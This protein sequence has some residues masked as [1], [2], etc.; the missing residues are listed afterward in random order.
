MLAYLERENINLHNLLVVHQRQTVLETYFYPYQPDSLHDIRSAAKSILSI[1]VGIALDEGR[2]QSVNQ[3]ILDF[4]PGRTFASV[5]AHKQRITLR[6]LLRM[7]S[8]L[9]WSDADVGKMMQSPDW[10]QFV[11]DGEMVAEPGTVFNY[12]TTNTHLLSAILQ[13]ATGMTALEYARQKLFDPLG[14]GTVRWQADPQGINMGGMGLWMT[15]R[16]MARIGQMMLYGG[17]GIVSES[18][19]KE[20][21]TPPD[22]EYAYLWWA[23]ADMF[24]AS[25]YGGQMI[26][27]LPQREMVVVLTAGLLD[28]PT[29]ARTLL[30][31]VIL[32]A[33][34]SH[35]TLPQ[36]Y[37]PASQFFPIPDTTRQISGQTYVLEANML[38][39]K[40]FRFEE[41]TVALTFSA[42]TITLPVGLDGLMRVSPVERL[43]LISDHDP[44]GLVGKWLDDRTFELRLYIINNPENWHI[45]LHFEASTVHI[46]LTDLITG[47][48][49][50]F[51]GH[52]R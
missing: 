3:P 10:I 13:Q 6:H 19:V 15:T 33:V 42:D 5:D 30:K 27:I 14:I 34:D 44:I 35:E 39:W 28:A 29:T 21:T 50:T 22:G 9:G 17:Q 12:S 40:A 41:Q 49:Q 26:Y 25:G 46:T 8:S 23:E 51:A 52:L 38:D 45:R 16:D 2:L 7:S 32:P 43:G 47:D 37:Q 31:N 48:Q 1:L 4:F 20:S 36:I 24:Y 18:W 11:L